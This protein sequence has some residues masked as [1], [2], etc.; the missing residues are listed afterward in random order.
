MSQPGMEQWGRDRRLRAHGRE[1][2]RVYEHAYE[3]EGSNGIHD[4]AY[5]G[6]RGFSLSRIRNIF[7]PFSPQFDSGAMGG[8]GGSYGGGMQGGSNGYLMTADEVVYNQ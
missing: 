6:S 2:A 1:V 8:Y 7:L 3:N 4:G 5:G